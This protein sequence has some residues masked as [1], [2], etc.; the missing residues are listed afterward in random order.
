[1]DDYCPFGTECICGAGVPGER[2]WVYLRTNSHIYGT[3][4]A[5]DYL[6]IAIILSRTFVNPSGRIFQPGSK[7]YF[8]PDS[9]K[10]VIVGE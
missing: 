5:H 6:E 1:M 8:G 2:H 7:V 9:I 3:V 4:D 10:E